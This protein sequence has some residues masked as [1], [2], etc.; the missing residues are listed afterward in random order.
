MEG[1]NLVYIPFTLVLIVMLVGFGI[2]MYSDY[3]AKPKHRKRYAH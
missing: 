2:I 3:Q 1:P